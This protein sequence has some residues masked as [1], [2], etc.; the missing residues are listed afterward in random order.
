MG[1]QSQYA[2]GIFDVFEAA[3]ALSLTALKLMPGG[4]INPFCEQLMVTSAPQASWRYSIEPSDEI[5]STRSRAGCFAASICLRTS[6]M[7]LTTPVE[8]SLW[9]MQTALMAWLRSSASLAY[10]TA[11]SAPRRQ[12]LSTQSTCS[13]SLVAISLQSV[14]KWPVSNIRTVSPGE[15]VLTSAASHAPVPD[16]G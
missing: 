1:S 14:A 10:T 9:T 4:S 11:G 5:V 7:R 16:P 2:R 15:S 8:V 12:S 6:A 3:S 13:P